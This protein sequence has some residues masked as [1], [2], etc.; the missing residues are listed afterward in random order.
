M[1]KLSAILF[2]LSVIQCVFSINTNYNLPKNNECDSQFKDII[3]I[4]NEMMN[5]FVD[6]ELIK[7]YEQRTQNMVMCLKF[8]S[9]YLAMLENEHLKEND[10]EN[11]KQ[12]Y[13]YTH[14]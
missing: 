12:Q 3:N 14:E 10:S 11:Y 4:D 7:A 6:D 2:V 9:K 1:M 13:D 5:D 8:Y